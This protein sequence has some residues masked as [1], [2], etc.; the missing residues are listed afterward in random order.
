[1][2]VDPGMATPDAL[3]SDESPEFLD[4]P[5][6]HESKSGGDAE[7]GKRAPSTP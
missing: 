7:T 2:D 1:M 3:N 4:I 5:V 6:V